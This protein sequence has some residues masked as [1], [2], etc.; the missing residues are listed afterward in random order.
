MRPGWSRPEGVN[1][2]STTTQVTTT[3]MPDLSIDGGTFAACDGIVYFLT[4]C[5]KASAKGT[6]RGTCC[7][8]CY[9]LIDERLGMAWLAADFVTQYPVWCIAQ[10]LTEGTPGVFASY[11]S[12]VAEALK[13]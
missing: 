5:C 12:K 8:S 10:G 11:A 7:R 4:D 3:T 6:E 2:T 1:M 13:L 9:R